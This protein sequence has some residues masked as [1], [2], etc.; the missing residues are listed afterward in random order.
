MAGLAVS[1][2]SL[3]AENNDLRKHICKLEAQLYT[4]KSYVNR[5][6]SVL[7]NKIESISNGF[8]KLL[9]NDFQL[10]LKKNTLLRKEKSKIEI[11][12]QNMSFL[13]NELLSKNEIIKLLMGK[14]SSVLYTMPKNSSP[15]ENDSL[16][17]RQS[18]H[19]LQPQ[20]G[21][22][23]IHSRFQQS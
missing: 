18:L 22:R 13:Q 1:A 5:E 16:I 3:D 20:S 17:Q 6:V 4:V 9:S 15:S 19:H 21:Q 7:T 23:D 14:Q 12:K 8:E 2:S 10:T 11:L